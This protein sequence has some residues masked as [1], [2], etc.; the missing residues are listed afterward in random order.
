MVKHWS[1]LP[2]EVVEASSLETL[3]VRLDGALS[4][5]IWLKMSLLT[6]R[7]LDQ[8]TFKGLFQPKLFYD[9]INLG[10]RKVVT[11]SLRLSRKLCLH[12]CCSKQVLSDA[13]S[14]CVVSASASCCF[15]YLLVKCRGHRRLSTKGCGKGH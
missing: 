5:L 14:L 7:E 4:N 10:L 8:M 3:K 12:S 1:R 9:S 2:R 13:F 11:S 6:A 15:C